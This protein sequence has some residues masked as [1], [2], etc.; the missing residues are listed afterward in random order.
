MSCSCVKSSK[1]VRNYHAYHAY[2]ELASV[3][4]HFGLYDLL[5]VVITRFTKAG[6]L[7]GFVRNCDPTLQ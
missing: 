2:R 6:D 4:A 3:C 1:N 5:I 7:D